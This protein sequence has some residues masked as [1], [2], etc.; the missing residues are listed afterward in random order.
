MHSVSY[1]RI[2]T[3]CCNIVAN[4]LSRTFWT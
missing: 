1:F 4:E 3:N 2:I